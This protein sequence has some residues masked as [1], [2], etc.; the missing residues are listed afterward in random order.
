MSSPTLNFIKLVF[1]TQKPSEEI[2]TAS[3][4]Y[5]EICSIFQNET[6]RSFRFVGPGSN[7]EGLPYWL[8]YMLKECHK[9]DAHGEFETIQTHNNFILNVI[10]FAAMEVFFVWIED[11]ECGGGTNIL[12]TA[13]VEQ[14]QTFFCGMFSCV[15]WT[16]AEDYLAQI[17]Y[18]D[19]ELAG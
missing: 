9:P 8:T 14:M 1:D 12:T 11:Q 19:A 2:I 7:S 10:R 15:G 4:L 13:T 18:E 17:P 5:D 6:I 16:T 3:D